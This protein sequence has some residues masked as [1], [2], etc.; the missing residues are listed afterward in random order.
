MSCRKNQQHIPS[1]CFRHELYR[2]QTDGEIFEE[3][4][5]E[6]IC[7]K[8]KYVFL[9]IVV[10]TL[11]M[12][13]CRL[14]P[15]TYPMIPH[16]IGSGLFE[17]AEL[18][19]QV[20][21]IAVSAEGRNFVN[22][23]RWVGN[24]QYSVAEL[25]P[26]G[27]LR[28][29]PDREWN[30]WDGTD[31][32]AGNHFV[33]VQSVYVDD[34]NY[35]WILDPASPGLRGV[36]KGGAKL[37]KVDPDTNKV[38]QVLKFDDSVALAASYL[39]DVRIDTMNDVAYI[40]DSGTGA[41]IVVDLQT[42]LSRRLLADDPSTKAEPGEKL[43]IGGRELLDESGKTPRIHVDGIALDP[44]NKFLYYH[45]LTAR[46][47]YRIHT[48][49]LKDAALTPAEVASHVEKLAD[50]GP[51]DGME[52]DQDFNL[53]FTSLEDSSVKRYRVYDGSILAVAGNRLLRWPDSMCIGPDENLYVTA[54]QID[55]MPRFNHGKD[56]REPP[57]KI[58]RIWL[59]PL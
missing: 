30:S 7:R 19:D 40:S 45:A 44:D 49:Y 12:V 15:V 50:T 59:G 21:G 17:F 27:S 2:H 18:A 47:L 13:G 48:R 51:V 57:Y 52:I 39:N 28:P 24:P 43:V 14:R 32:S 41:I 20:T 9:L 34:D 38:E 53:Y 31:A 6:G 54:S 5:M 8:R 23:P 35:L 46:T 16:P 10:I 4:E 25:M 56:K 3:G 36:V 11:A 42:G 58:F 37:V 26:D 22:F 33:C 29:Y 1:G 55:G